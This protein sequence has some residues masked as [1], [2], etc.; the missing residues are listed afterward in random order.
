LTPVVDNTAFASGTEIFLDENYDATNYYLA[1][2]LGL[3]ARLTNG[4]WSL[5]VFGKVGFGAV[6]EKVDIDGSTR[7]V[8][9]GTEAASSGGLFAN[10]TS[11]GSETDRMQ[12]AIIPEFGLNGRYQVSSKTALRFGYSVLFIDPV[13]RPSDL[14]DHNTI[15]PAL[16]PPT[17]LSGDRLTIDRFGDSSMILHGFHGGIELRY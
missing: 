1:L 7:I 9:P 14:L 4:P 5:E 6:W 8:V 16:L 11:I 10:S 13:L 2:Q 15:T 3:D 17:S 12:F